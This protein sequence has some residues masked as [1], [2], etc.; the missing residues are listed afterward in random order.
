MPPGKF[1]EFENS[2]TIGESA[3]TTLIQDTVPV[4]P[5][6]YEVLYTY[7]SGQ[8]SDITSAIDKLKQDSHL[9]QEK[10]LRALYDA[11]LSDGK[12]LDISEDIGAR[13]NEEIRN[14][15]E[16]MG[17]AG[18]KSKTCD[19]ALRKIET[20]FSSVKT[21]Q[22]LHSVVEILSDITRTIA[23]NNRTLTGE[24]HR[25][26]QQIEALHHDLEKARNEGNTDALTGLSNRKHF[27]TVLR[28]SFELL[29]E[30]GEDLS[31]LMVDIDHFK[32][33]NDTFGH[34]TGDQVLR[35]VAHTLKSVLKGRDLPARWG[36][37][38]FAVIL[39]GTSSQN[40]YIVAEQIRKAIAAKELIKRSS[41]ENMGSINV[42]IGVAQ[43]QQNDDPQNL[44]E[45]ADT[46]LYKAKE[47]GRNRCIIAA[48]ESD[49]K[50]AS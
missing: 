29:D 14:I 4:W 47:T 8:N 22:Q 32:T 36:G 7:E 39:P 42:S 10:D 12:L 48:Q 6:M 21:P 20:K 16:T 28:A 19:N 1:F 35:L 41:G 2:L 34:Q 46:A 9:L 15:V 50:I 40:A 23:D 31:L 26:S 11:H 13:I 5:E 45:Q 3:F 44:I 33:F 37:E 38:E 49:E 25:S 18:K 24:L 43:T 30:H 27:D 17:S